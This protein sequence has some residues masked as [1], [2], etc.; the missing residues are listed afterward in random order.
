MEGVP[1]EDASLA[2]K[3]RLGNLCWVYDN[4]SITIEGKT[5]LAFNEDVAARFRAYGWRTEHVAD[6]NDT[7]A[8]TRAFAAFRSDRGAPLLIVVDSHIGYG[9]PHKQD[10]EKAH[11]EALGEAEVRLTKAFYGWPEDA[12]F[13]V[14]DGVMDHFDG[15]LGARGAGSP[16]LWA[17]PL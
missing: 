16:A 17:A 1:S 9:S 13:L 11:G 6:A 7:A 12:Q 2:G 15:H 3:I 14:P 8:L 5:S 10:S 4:N